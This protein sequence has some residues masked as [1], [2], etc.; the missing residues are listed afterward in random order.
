M[1]YAES[2]DVPVTRAGLPYIMSANSMDVWRIRLYIIMATLDVTLVALA[3]FGASWAYL[4]AVVDS[5]TVSVLKF[6]VVLYTF[7]AVYNGAYS[8]RSMN[9]FSFS[10]GRLLLAISQAVALVIF[11]FF[12]TKTSSNFS[13]VVL[14]LGVGLFAFLAIVARYIIIHALTKWRGPSFSNILIIDANGP[15]VDIPNAYRLCARQHALTPDFDDPEFLNRFGSYVKN[16][17]RVIVSCPVGQRESWTPILRCAGVR[18]ELVSDALQALGVIGVHREA[19]FTTVVVSTGPL[20]LRARL[21]KRLTDIVIGGALL[22]MLLPVM[23]AIAIAIKLDDGGP[24]LFSQRR[25][26]RSNLF[27]K[28][29]KFRSMSVANSDLSGERSTARQ[30]QRITKVGRFIRMT[31]LDELP[32][33]INVLRGEMS[34][35][36]PRP[37]ALGSNV[38][39]KAFWQLDDRYWYRHSLKPGV[40]GLAQVKGF[41]GATEKESD[42]TERVRYDLSYIQNWSPWLDF[43]IMFK[44]LS[45]AVHKNAY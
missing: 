14:G 21:F 22:L 2:P 19:N 23:I 43:I 38:N 24:V 13:R 10:V 40:T 18:G 6:L 3:F 12:Y 9:S 17:D 31:S 44:T 28:V 45:V 34:L 30:D 11:I 1:K 20:G 7:I 8:T 29:L 5:Q 26:G 35:V 41:R 37:H 4:G 27:F 16:M 15:S 36:G 39:N 25:V 42:L 33:L 32:Q